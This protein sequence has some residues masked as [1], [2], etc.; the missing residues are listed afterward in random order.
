[1][2]KLSLT[3][4]FRN[5]IFTPKLFLFQNKIPR[6][7]QKASPPSS[8]ISPSPRIS[9]R[10]SFVCCRHI[11]HAVFQSKISNYCIMSKRNWEP[12]ISITLWLVNYYQ[13]CQISIFPPHQSIA[14][15]DTP[16]FI[17]QIHQMLKLPC[18]QWH[19]EFLNGWI[20]K[21]RRKCPEW[22]FFFTRQKALQGEHKGNSLLVRPFFFSGFDTFDYTVSKNSVRTSL[23]TKKV[24]ILTW[25]SLP[26]LERSWNKISDYDEKKKK[27]TQILKQKCQK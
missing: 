20:E 17:N 12:E 3:N 11:W 14:N 13:S 24:N 27:P 6:L 26:F 5:I 22:P 23:L 25:I 4:T 7:R 16:R 8:W 2:I 15:L 1:M 10:Y 19:L 9:P 18:K 21:K